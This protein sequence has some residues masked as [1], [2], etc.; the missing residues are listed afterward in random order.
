[1]DLTAIIILDICNDSK[2]YLTISML[3]IGHKVPGPVNNIVIS[4]LHFIF[5]GDA[6]FQL[7]VVDNKHVAFFSAQVSR[8][9]EFYP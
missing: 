1:M 4:C 6:Y 9:L 2:W 8:P 3:F 5:K 7:E